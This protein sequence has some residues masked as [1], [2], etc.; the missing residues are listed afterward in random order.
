MANIDDELRR[1]MEHKGSSG[2]HSVPAVSHPI[3]DSPAATAPTAATFPHRRSTTPERQ[4]ATLAGNS[5]AARFGRDVRRRRPTPSFGASRCVK[6]RPA[7]LPAIGDSLA[8]I[9]RIARI[10]EIPRGPPAG[11]EA[12]TADNT[13]NT[14]NSRGDRSCRRR[15]GRGA[16]RWGGV[17][18]RDG[19]VGEAPVDRRKPAR[20][21]RR[22]SIGRSDAVR[23]V[24]MGGATSKSRR[25]RPGFKRRLLAED[26]QGRRRHFCAASTSSNTMAR[27][28]ALR[29]GRRGCCGSPIRRHLAEKPAARRRSSRR[30]PAGLQGVLEFRRMTHLCQIE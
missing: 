15:D 12:R 28:V 1:G 10:A 7:T 6:T 22:A 21:Q 16:R 17:A 8:G 5:L 23:V 25:R 13:V 3:G 27:A 11:M 26:R 20:T 4:P 30:V 9:A 29:H 18:G 14:D 19:G 24:T 2:C